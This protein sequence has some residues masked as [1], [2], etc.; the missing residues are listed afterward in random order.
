MPPAE[1]S[2]ADPAASA[3]E[4]SSLHIQEPDAVQPSY[5]KNGTHQ[6]DLHPLDAQELNALDAP[7]SNAVHGSLPADIQ[8]NVSQVLES[9]SPED[10]AHERPEAVSGAPDESVSADEDSST[11][12]SSSAAYEDAGPDIDV[13]AANPS[14]QPREPEP[15]TVRKVQPME[16]DQFAV[17]S[18]GSSSDGSASDNPDEVTPAD[19][20][21]ALGDDL[22]AS[23]EDPT[24]MLLSTADTVSQEPEIASPGIPSEPAVVHDEL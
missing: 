17:P 8:S 18:Y 6:P 9:L 15:E 2:Q 21:M 16:S 3:A 12:S 23:V 24:D 11:A 22:G 13:V 20:D 7:A 5:D 10:R 1:E 4:E 14:E 19:S